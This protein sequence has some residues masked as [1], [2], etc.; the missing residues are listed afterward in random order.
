MRWS[1][2]LIERRAA[3]I[4]ALL[5]ALLAAGRASANPDRDTM[6][7]VLGGTG[8]LSTRMIYPSLLELQKYGVLTKNSRVVAVAP[9]S[10]AIPGASDAGFHQFLDNKGVKDAH[11]LQPVIHYQPADLGERGDLQKLGARLDAIDEADRAAG[12]LK[13]PRERIFYLALPPGMFK[14]T[15]THLREVGLVGRTA[16]VTNRVVVEKPVGTDLE[17]SEKINSALAE[18]FDDENVYRMDHYLGKQG[19]RDLYRLRFADRRFQHIWNNHYIDH[20]TVKAN[21]A[22]DVQGRGKFYDQVGATRDMVQSHLLQLLAI[23]LMDEPKDETTRAVR[24]AK[25]R[26]FQA[27]RPIPK[28]RLAK[29][30]MRGQYVDRQNPLSGYLHEPGVDPHSSTETFVSVRTQLAGKQ[31]KGVKVR[32]ESGKALNEK[33]TEVTVHFKRLPNDL[34]A[35]LGQP[36]GHPA[37]LTIRID[38]EPT[39]TLN[40]SPLALRNAKG[41]GMELSAYARQLREILRGNGAWFPGRNEVRA[42]WRFTDP[43]VEHGATRKPLLYGKGTHGPRMPHHRRADVTRAAKPP[44]ATRTRAAR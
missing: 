25:A 23:T 42:S 18:V 29:S 9:P 12:R 30:V 28:T 33:A 19:T 34:A 17:S 15:L 26:A 41:S 8:D 21:E 11:K 2:D 27:L 36:P 24:D 3:A 40:G 31:W 32:L 16:K 14:Q 5:L 43:L 38:P 1:I 20:I 6:L 35:E 22:L 13:G 10:P 4:A 37:A 39:I 7:V 44:T